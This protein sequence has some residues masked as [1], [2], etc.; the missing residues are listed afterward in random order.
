MKLKGIIEYILRVILF[1]LFIAQL[2]DKILNLYLSLNSLA[3]DCLH[4]ILP[5][6]N[7][8][9]EINIF[10]GSVT[11]FFLFVQ[12]IFSSYFFA[13]IF[14]IFKKLD[15][16]NGWLS[17]LIIL[18]ISNIY[19]NTYNYIDN[20]GLF[21]H[22]IKISY[23]TIDWSLIPAFLLYKYFQYLTKKHPVPFEKIGYYFS[24]EFYENI[25]DKFIPKNELDKIWNKGSKE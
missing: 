12:Y 2:Q 3:M 7:T 10:L 14:G 24:I 6:A 5:I 4:K 1:L 19:L 18:L 16:L 8:N 20:N 13:K 21:G 23:S 15:G 17:F 25:F 22:N 9:E 11:I